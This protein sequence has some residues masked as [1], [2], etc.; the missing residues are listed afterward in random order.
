MFNNK[1]KS[2][3]EHGMAIFVPLGTIK[4]I[5][6]SGKTKTKKETK[7]ENIFLNNNL[8]KYFKNQWLFQIPTAT[9]TTKFKV[10]HTIS[11]LL[12]SIFPPPPSP[13]INFGSGTEQ[14]RNPFSS[15]KHGKKFVLKNIKTRLNKNGEERKGGRER[16][17]HLRIF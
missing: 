3:D 16:R 6:T 14:K 12:P 11:I 5:I 9:T 10:M 2:I 15:K 4:I 13:S 7:T 8:H 1:K 17:K